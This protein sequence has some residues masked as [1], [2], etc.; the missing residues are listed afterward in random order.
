[1]ISVWPKQK[2]LEIDVSKALSRHTPR[3]EAF[4]LG[5]CLITQAAY[6][7][8]TET[9]QDAIEDEDMAILLS[10]KHALQELWPYAQSW[11]DVVKGKKDEEARR[12]NVTDERLRR[13]AEEADK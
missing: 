4:Y 3:S 10:I 8:F 11:D 2:R 1:M 5:Y 6:R 9:Y 13:E 12:S 7:H